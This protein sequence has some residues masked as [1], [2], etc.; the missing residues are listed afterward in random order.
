MDTSPSKLSLWLLAARP[1]TLPAAVAPVL[2]GTAVAYDDGVFS[3]LPAFAAFLG[4]LLLQIAVNLANDYFDAQ[5]DVDSDK[6]LGPVRVTQTGLIPAAQVKLAMILTLTAAALVFVYLTWVGGLVI[7]LV[8][9]ASVLAAL[10]YSGGPYP[11]AS[12]GLGELF[13][14]IFFGLVAVCGTYWVQAHTLS[15]LVVYASF[16]PGLLISAIMVV[17]NFRDMETDEPAGKLTLAVRL[18]KTKTMRLYRIMLWV[19]YFAVVCLGIVAFKSSFLLPLVTAP[20]A[21]ILYR[22][23]GTFSGTAL[24]STLAKTAQLSLLFSLFFAWGIIL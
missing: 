4:A 16:A 13:V 12:N 18:G 11:L 3:F 5:N 7:F 15:L 9:V 10:A 1:K 22:E 6:R 14:F 19:P 17:N 21:V 8:A 24:N 20:M 23:I 2:V